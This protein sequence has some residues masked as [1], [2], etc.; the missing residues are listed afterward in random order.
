MSV[1]LGEVHDD[2][3]KGVWNYRYNAY[4][5]LVLQKDANG[6]EVTMEYDQLG[7]LKKR[8]D[9][10][11]PNPDP[12]LYPNDLWQALNDG[13]TTWQYDG[14]IM[15][16]GKLASVSNNSTGYSR[17]VDYDAYGRTKNVTSTIL[18]EQYVT[19][20]TY[21]DYGRLSTI[22]YPAT[23]TT[24]GGTSRLEVQQHY[25]PVDGYLTKL[26]N[27]ATSAVYWEGTRMN[28]RGQVEAFT[29]S[30]W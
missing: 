17:S 24:G 15:G 29:I 1:K 5:E 16:I 12:S 20:N 2:P 19:T 13:E 7:R 3:D 4:G 27:T 26:T 21:D 28:A 9:I 11:A 23:P 30:Q 6:Q 25:D 18:A 22:Q 14:A 10:L 8:Y